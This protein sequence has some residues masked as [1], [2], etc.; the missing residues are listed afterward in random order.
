MGDITFNATEKLS[1]VQSYS[2]GHSMVSLLAIGGMTFIAPPVAL[3]LGVVAGGFLAYTKFSQTKK[4]NFSNE[5]RTWMQDQIQRVQI[6]VNNTFQRAQVDLE[7]TMR[8]T[9]VGL[10]NEREAENQRAIAECEQA[11]KD[12]QNRRDADRKKAS[13]AAESMRSLR[14][15]GLALLEEVN[16]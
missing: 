1:L 12:D 13:A 3:G 5:F 6:T 15:Q 14:K 7:E 2:S 16:R 9:L 8:K 11:L 4:V 10:L